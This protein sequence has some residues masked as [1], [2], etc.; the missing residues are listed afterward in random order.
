MEII[1]KC[2]Y[3]IDDCESGEIYQDIEEEEDKFEKP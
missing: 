3:L 2:L 1:E